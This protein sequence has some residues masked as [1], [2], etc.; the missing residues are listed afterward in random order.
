MLPELQSAKTLSD[1]QK[2]VLAALD[3][4]PRGYVTTYA[5]LAEFI[6]CASPRAVGQALRKNPASPQIPCHRVV[7]SDGSLGGFFGSTSPEA[8]SR[9]VALLAA[10]GVVIGT[11]GRVPD[12][13]ILR[14]LKKDRYRRKQPQ[15]YPSDAAK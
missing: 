9:K 7:R 14:N 15:T 2:C 5:A 11:T 4:V 12:H 3:R 10:E 8:T 13:L 1:F 6:D